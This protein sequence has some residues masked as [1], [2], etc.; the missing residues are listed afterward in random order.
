MNINNLFED[1]KQSDITGSCYNTFTPKRLIVIEMQESKEQRKERKH[2]EEEAFNKYI[3]DN[4]KVLE[5]WSGHKYKEI[6]FD[7][8][9]EKYIELLPTF[10]SKILYHRHLYFIVIDSND[11]VFGHYHDGEIDNGDKESSEEDDDGC[12]CYDPHIFLFTL[13]SNGRSGV[14][15]FDKKYLRTYTNIQND[16]SFYHICNDDEGSCCYVSTIDTND[17]CIYADDLKNSFKGIT[18]DKLIGEAD[19]DEFIVRKLVVLEMKLDIT[20]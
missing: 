14:E 19:C 16:Y 5:E 3:K 8:N 15:K 20:S 13:N 17:S 10:S 6:I 9:N 2:R 12:D 4:I 7:S 11:N 1:V 18:K